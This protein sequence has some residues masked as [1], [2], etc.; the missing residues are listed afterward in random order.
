MYLQNALESVKNNLSYRFYIPA[1]AS[2]QDAVE[3]LEAMKSQLESM[4]AA[5]AL[6]EDE[7][8]KEEDKKVAPQEEKAAE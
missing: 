1:G 5:A 4:S 7:R 8:K 2:Y 6:A 3:V